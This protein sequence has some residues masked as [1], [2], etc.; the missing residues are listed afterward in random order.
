MFGAAVVNLGFDLPTGTFL[1][2][3]FV[4]CAVILLALAVEGR[5]NRRIVKAPQEEKLLRPPGYSLS[6]KLDALAEQL[7]ERAFG[8]MAFCAF[9]GVT[10]DPI[11]KAI[12]SGSTTQFAIVA[13]FATA[14]VLTPAIAFSLSVY[15][16]VK[17]MRKVRLGLR[18]EQATAEALHEVAD[19]GY[20]AFHD[21][22]GGKD[23]NIDHVAV[24]RMGVFL[25]ETKA[26]LK[27]KVRGN[28]KPHVVFFDGET[29]TFPFGKDK[30]AGAQA[31]RNARWLSD[32]L[33]KKT[34]EPVHVEPIVVLP[35]WFVEGQGNDVKAMNC[36]Y[37]KAYLRN[38]SERLPQS[39]VTRITAALEELNRTIEFS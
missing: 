9:S 4:P 19:A 7:L 13:I 10:L 39:Q 5:L 18:G 22:E 23:W 15:R 25:L 17:C 34:G 30:T 8:A 16:T 38:Q 20:R 2:A 21:I 32:H 26:R 29:L 33:A 28:Q 1:A 24:G 12:A 35:G 11:S 31:K 37:L 27:R 14:L 3:A 36:K 6:L